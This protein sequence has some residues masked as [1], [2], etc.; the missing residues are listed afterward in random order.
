MTVEEE[1]DCA[2][3][4]RKGSNCDAVYSYLNSLNEEE[5]FSSC[6][7][8]RLGIHGTDMKTGDIFLK[9]GLSFCHMGSRDQIQEA[10]LCA[11]TLT[12]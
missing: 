11:S 1:I 10:S 12:H 8:G 6:I 2:L 5:T 3:S 4:D 7:L 9:S